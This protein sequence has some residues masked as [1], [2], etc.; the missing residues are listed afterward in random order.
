MNASNYNKTHVQIHLP[1]ARK[2]VDKLRK[3]KAKIS[4]AIARQVYETNFSQTRVH[5]VIT[6]PN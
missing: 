3:F 4:L 1:R 6:S 2:M 5:C